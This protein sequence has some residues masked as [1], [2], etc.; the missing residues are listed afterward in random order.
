[1]TITAI[2]YHQGMSKAIDGV[3]SS[4]KAWVVREDEYATEIVIADTEEDAVKAYASVLHLR[5]MPH[6]RPKERYNIKKYKKESE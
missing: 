6:T 1:M 3:C 2:K 4:S 5:Q